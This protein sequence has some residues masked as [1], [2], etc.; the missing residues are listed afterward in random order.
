MILTVRRTCMISTTHVCNFTSPKLALLLTDLTSASL[1]TTIISSPFA[2]NFQWERYLLFYIYF[3]RA[4]CT[5]AIP[6]DVEIS[7]FKHFAYFTALI[8]NQFL[9]N[10]PFVKCILNRFTQKMK[11]LCNKFNVKI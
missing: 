11:S 10:F 8:Y 2:C 5:P 1:T 3:W 7:S 6:S 4:V 9:A